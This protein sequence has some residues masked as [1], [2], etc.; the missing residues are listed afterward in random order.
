[1]KRL[2]LIVLITVLGIAARGN[3]STRKESCPKPLSG[4]ERIFVGP[5][6]LALGEVHGTKEIPRLVGDLA[7]NALSL[8]VPVIVGYEIG[9]DQQP[10]FDAFVDSDG[11]PTARQ[12]LLA[13]EFWRTPYKDGR[14][15]EALMGL[16]ER[17]RRMHRAGAN[18]RFAAIERGPHGEDRDKQ[19]A[20]GVAQLRA[21]SPDAI[22]LLVAGSN[23]TRVNAG[24]PMGARLRARGIPLVSLA[25]TYQTGTVWTCVNRCG[26][27]EMEGTDRGKKP[28]IE[29][30]PFWHGGFDGMIYIGKISGSPPA[31]PEG[32][33]AD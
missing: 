1:M 20:D 32:S 17:I 18:I 12:K 10:A 6:V 29:L 8:G 19:M 11:G 16:L 33:V 28:F 31:V 27:H 7:C 5:T 4:L 24:Y 15:S 30:K 25:I 21:E 14:Q 23:H 13:G 3:A 22:I 26:L 9:G 2:N